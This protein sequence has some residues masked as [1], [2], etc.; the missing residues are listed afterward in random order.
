M[1]AAL[2]PVTRESAVQM[3]E[4]ESL[5]LSVYPELLLYARRR[6]GGVPAAEQIVADAYDD[7]LAGTRGQ[8]KPGE[9]GRV[10]NP[11]E[12]PDL[13]VFFRDVLASKISHERRRRAHHEDADP[14]AIDAGSLG[15][16]PADALVEEKQRM[17]RGLLRI[18]AAER[19]LKE[20]DD[21]LALA[22]LP[23]IVALDLD[24]SEIARQAGS[25]VSAVYRAIARVKE[26]LKRAIVAHPSSGHFPVAGD[27]SAGREGA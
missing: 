17:E 20:K 27:A 1:A 22:A 3:L 2:D 12:S 21:A 5:W 24:P 23:K 13:E 10:W 4:D 7:V 26:E 19:A 9:T 18:A 16:A 8:Q 11:N 15:P 25:P 6:L 14:D